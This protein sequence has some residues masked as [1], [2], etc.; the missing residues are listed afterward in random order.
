MGAMKM[1]SGKAIANYILEK[2]IAEGVPISPMKLIKLVYVA[3]GWCLALTDRPL[4]REVVEAW[5]YGPVIPEIYHA[6][7]EYVDNPIV[8]KAYISKD[9][10]V[11]A[12]DILD[13]EDG[14]T[15]GELLDSVWEALKD[16][17]A[18]ELSNITHQPNTPWYN[19]SKGWKFWF[20]KNL[21]N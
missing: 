7:K 5:Q 17:T 13:P 8:T 21:P 20:M 19:V 6:F 15:V 10:E 2:G 14:Y 3:H 11:E 1:Y 12:S 18:L 9:E 16:F 4:I